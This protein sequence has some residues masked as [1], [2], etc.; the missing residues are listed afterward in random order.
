VTTHFLRPRAAW[1]C[2]AL[3]GL[4]CGKGP[5]S[6]DLI[7]EA[8]GTM[9]LNLSADYGYHFGAL[10]ADIDGAP[11]TLIGSSSGSPGPYQPG[12]IT[13]QAGSDATASFSVT[14]SLIQQQGAGQLNVHDGNSVYSMLIPTLHSARSL[15]L[16]PAEDPL[17]GGDSVVLSSPV[18][19]DV[20]GGNADFMDAQGHLCMSQV[21]TQGSGSR[22]TLVMAA[23]F[24]QAWFCNPTPAPGTVVS[25]SLQSPFA[26]IRIAI[27]A[28][29]GGVSCSA[30]FSQTAAL[31]AH[32]QL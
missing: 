24:Q 30:F 25:G 8:D 11:L 21:T 5:K 20:I 32:A 3:V 4:A 2:T 7:T 6:L 28:C 16:V 31:P 1:L 12:G 26:I 27:S 10:A 23:D 14:P 18:D 19:S 9:L 15:S 29:Q 13:D 17:R 22:L